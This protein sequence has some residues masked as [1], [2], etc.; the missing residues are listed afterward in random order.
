VE[1]DAEHLHCQDD[2]FDWAMATFV[3][4]CMP[5]AIYGLRKLEHVRIDRLVIGIF[6]DICNPLA[7][8]VSRANINRR[9][10]ETI[11]RSRLSIETAKDLTPRGLFKPI[12]VLS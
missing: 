8:H 9:T 11:V 1:I 7:V 12:T 6:M 5:N 10:V 4:C 2:T 3:F